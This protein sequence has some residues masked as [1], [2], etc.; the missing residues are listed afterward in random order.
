MIIKLLLQLVGCKLIP[1]VCNRLSCYHFF[2]K[3]NTNFGGEKKK[4]V[5][6]FVFLVA[7]HIYTRNNLYE[8]VLCKQSNECFCMSQSEFP[9]KYRFFDMKAQQIHE[10]NTE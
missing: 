6:C 10:I 9:E 1:N 2:Q 7:N 4:I 8:C 5:E 3:P